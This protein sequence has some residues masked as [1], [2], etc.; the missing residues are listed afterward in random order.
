MK[1]KFI[2]KDLTEN[3]LLLFIYIF[4]SIILVA[5]VFIS[6]YLFGRAHQILENPRPTAVAKT[7]EQLPIKP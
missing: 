3:P 4:I 5:N 7:V 1:K 2:L 6:G